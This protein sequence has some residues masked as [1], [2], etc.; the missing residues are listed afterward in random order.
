MW[1]QALSMQ[2]C[3]RS[4]YHPGS[5]HK[6]S[7]AGAPE[8]AQL[9]PQLSQHW[10]GSQFHSRLEKRTLAQECW[11]TP[12]EEQLLVPVKYCHL[13]NWG[14]PEPAPSQE[15]WGSCDR[16]V[17]SC[18]SQVNSPDYYPLWRVRRG[19]GA[20]LCWRSYPQETHIKHKYLHETKLF[21]TS[22]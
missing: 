19:G 14:E 7:L 5:F 10:A 1:L 6:G 20:I 22:R 16:W 12:D 8:A 11:T 4:H 17:G 9:F 3:F 15:T 2:L 18:H 13:W 21:L